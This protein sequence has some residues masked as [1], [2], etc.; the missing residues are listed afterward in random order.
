MGNLLIIL[1]I[2]A[3]IPFALWASW[4]IGGLVLGGSMYLIGCLLEVFQKLKG[5]CINFMRDMRLMQKN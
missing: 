1:L 2:I 4:I 5:K 3:L